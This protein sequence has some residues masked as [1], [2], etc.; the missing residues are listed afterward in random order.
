MSDYIWGIYHTKRKTWFA[1][2]YDHPRLAKPHPCFC[3]RNDQ[4]YAIFKEMEKKDMSWELRPST[5][6]ERDN[7]KVEYE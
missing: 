5:K 4:L 7:A 1:F 6:K 3:D 2:G